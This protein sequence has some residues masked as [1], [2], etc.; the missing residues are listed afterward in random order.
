MNQA[1]TH[2]LRKLF[3]RLNVFPAGD[4][5]LKQAWRRAKIDYNKQPR[6]LRAAYLK[7]VAAEIALAE[8]LVTQS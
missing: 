4:A 8:T 2:I 5:R 3:N 7:K 6:N 1:K